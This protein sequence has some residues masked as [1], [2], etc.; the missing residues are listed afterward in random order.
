MLF[1]L[2]RV[3]L[4]LE[5]ILIGVKQE[6][7]RGEINTAIG[8]TKFSGCLTITV[9]RYN[10]NNNVRYVSVVQGPGKKIMARGR[11]R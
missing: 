9:V 7:S 10:A 6:P 11:I 1:C 3:V 5:L 4:G 8:I 2:N